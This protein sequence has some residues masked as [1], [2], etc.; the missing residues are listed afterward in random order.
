[1][2]NE[3]IEDQRPLTEVVTAKPVP[4]SKP[5]RNPSSMTIKE[6]A[7]E[8]GVS[9]STVKRLKQRKQISFHKVR[10]SLRFKLSD[11]ESYRK[12]RTLVAS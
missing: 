7:Q 10:G 4:S 8:L 2:I 6:A 9:V 3:M 1:M 11:L 12:K 5:P